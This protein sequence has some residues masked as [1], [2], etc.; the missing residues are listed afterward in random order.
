MQD[1]EIRRS[2]LL[3]TDHLLSLF[4]SPRQFIARRNDKM[5]E[6]HRYLAKKLPVDR[7]GSEE[8]I[9]LS[10]RLLDELP[11]FLGSV[12]RY[13]DII[14]EHFADVQD[15]YQE[16]V[17]EFWE[18]YTDHFAAEN[19]R[20]SGPLQHSINDMMSRL[21]AGLGVPVARERELW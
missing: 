18:R 7:R 17:Q 14:T 21:A 3:K 16:A 1:H 10:N 12:T 2:L 6:H 9:D 4:E 5:L 11:R 19:R 20:R 8:F 15:A 13:Y